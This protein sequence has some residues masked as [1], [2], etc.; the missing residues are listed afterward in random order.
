MTLKEYCKKTEN[1]TNK[2]YYIFKDK[3]I[4]CERV[5]AKNTFTFLQLQ[6]EKI[7]KVETKNNIDYITLDLNFDDYC[8][9]AY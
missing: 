9:L 6:C 3:T 4:Y 8:E 2:L 5:K 1:S 7:V